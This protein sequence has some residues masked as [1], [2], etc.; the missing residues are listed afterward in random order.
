[1]GN[2][3][4]FKLKQQLGAAIKSLEPSLFATTRFTEQWLDKV[5]LVSHER[6][7]EGN[8]KKAEHF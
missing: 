6:R 4:N 2:T 5:G 1:M 7:I 3:S 8:S